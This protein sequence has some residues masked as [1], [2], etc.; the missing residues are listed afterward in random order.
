MPRGR[1]K[2]KQKLSKAEEVQG[3]VKEQVTCPICFDIKCPIY[4]CDN[5]HHI[6]ANCRARLERPRCPSCR[7]QINARARGLERLVVALTNACK[8]PDCPAVFLPDSRDVHKE[9]EEHE[10]LCDFQSCSCPFP[11]CREQL[12]PAQLQAHVVSQHKCAALPAGGL[13]EM[14]QSSRAQ[15]Q[16]YYARLDRTPTSPGSLVLLAARRAGGRTAMQLECRI[17]F[18]KLVCCF[19]DLCEHQSSIYLKEM[20]W[21][22]QKTTS[23]VSGE[24]ETV[25]VKFFILPADA[26]QSILKLHVQRRRS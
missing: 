4:Q 11:G 15:E 23:F 5:G 16:T 9:Q 17:G 13:I 21:K 7:G 2:K 25:A 20:N 8:W 6:C 3:V 10:R 24:D 26:M 18:G 1:P 22:R 14:L 12:L 19:L